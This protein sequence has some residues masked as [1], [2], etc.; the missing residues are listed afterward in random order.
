MVEHRAERLPIGFV[1]FTAVWNCQE[2]AVLTFVQAW[3]QLE[4]ITMGKYVLSTI[5]II[6]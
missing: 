6:S 2:K 5:M 3:Q 1:E 4:R